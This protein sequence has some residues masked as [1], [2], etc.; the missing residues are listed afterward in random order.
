MDKEV[1]EI[2]KTQDRW[3]KVKKKNIEVTISSPYPEDKMETIIKSVNKLIE[4]Y[5]ENKHTNYIR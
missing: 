5:E 3:I 1:K 2:T 4:K